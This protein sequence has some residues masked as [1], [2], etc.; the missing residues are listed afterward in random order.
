MISNRRQ[1]LP[2][3]VV[4][5]LFTSL[6]VFTP[7]KAEA[8]LSLDLSGKIDNFSFASV[9]GSAEYNLSIM[10]NGD[11][12]FD[13]VIVDVSFDNETWNPLNVTF[14]VSEMSTEGSATFGSLAQGESAEAQISVLVG[15]YYEFLFPEV[16]M[17]LTVNADG[18]YYSV[19]AIVVVTNWVAENFPSQPPVNSFSKSG[20]S[21][22]YEI[23]VRNIAVSRNTT[24]NSTSPMAI[25]DVI[26]IRDS[27]S[28]GSWFV[29]SDNKEWNNM[30]ESGTLNGME[31]GASY[32]FIVNLNLTGN[33][34]AGDRLFVME[35]SSTTPSSGGGG[36]GPGGGGPGGGGPGG[37]GGGGDNTYL[38]TNG[39]IS[40]TVTVSP[41]YGVGLTGGGHRTVD[42]SEGK[43]S[44]QWSVDINNLGNTPDTFELIWDVSGV[45]SGWQ[46]SSLPG[47][48]GLLDWESNSEID[49]YLDV[50]ADALVTQSASFSLT[51]KSLGSG[52]VVSS[53]SF[54]VSVVQHYGFSISVD[55]E[56]NSKSPGKKADFRFNITNKGNGD[57]TFTI[58][59]DGSPL[60]DPNL[61][62]NSITLGPGASSPFIASAVVPADK[63]CS[64][65]GCD[66]ASFQVFVSSSDNQT[67]LNQT[68]SV[69]T[70]QVYDLSLSYLKPSDGKV[71]VTQEAAIQVQLNVTNL[72]NGPDLVSFSMENA[73][74]WAKLTTTEPIVIGRSMSFKLNID[75]SPNTAALSGRDYTFQ[76][77]AVSFDGSEFRS[78]DL[79][80]QIDVKETEGEEVE[81][82]KLEE[83]DDEGLPG[84]SIFTSLLA[85]TF[86][87]F[88]R[89]KN[90]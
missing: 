5:L 48:S 55:S 6:F 2:L 35:A 80:V 60:W 78:D 56:A 4:A 84:F 21:H 65:N 82:E 72:G 11:V 53:Q 77:K 42:V 66:K 8:S 49:I 32:K 86:I 52:S 90:L 26:T 87:L 37:G 29:T 71:T 12:N 62:H 31:A 46:L 22:N 39:L 1:I 69:S 28:L 19:E 73:P 7:V 44:A 25:D 89:R 61:T 70:V 51:A 9:N 58:V 59:I 74:S 3:L 47:T 63:G 67:V 24:D 85:F 45:P 27:S 41:F 34:R 40:F 68:V 64:T 33:L 36:G 17:T 15:E 76:I 83:A 38:Q 16:P 13:D 20:P 57:D 54:S 10:N 18:Q 14:T 81:T 23:I 43:A 79:T 88:T 75:L 50:A 30:S